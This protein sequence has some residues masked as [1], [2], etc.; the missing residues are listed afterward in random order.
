MQVG[1]RGVRMHGYVRRCWMHR[2]VVQKVLGL[3]EG[4]CLDNALGGVVRWRGGESQG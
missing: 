4:A 1:Q 3:Q 2:V